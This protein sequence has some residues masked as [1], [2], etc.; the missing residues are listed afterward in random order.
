MVMMVGIGLS[1][2]IK[3]SI[4]VMIIFGNVWV[5]FIMCWNSGIS[6]GNGV[7]L[8]VES[9]VIIVLLIVFR[10]VEVV[11]MFSVLISVGRVCCIWLGRLLVFCYVLEIRVVG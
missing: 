2:S 6:W 11:V 3:I 8:C 1:F 4:S 10:S 9:K 7:S 5:M